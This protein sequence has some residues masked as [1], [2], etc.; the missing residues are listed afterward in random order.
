MPFCIEVDGVGTLPVELNGHPH[1]AAVQAAFEAAATGRVHRAEPLPP[2]GS[3]GP[4]YAL[5]QLS[6]DGQAA[7]GRLTPGGERLARGSLCLV[8]G[9]SSRALH[10]RED[11]STN[12]RRN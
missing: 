6:L 7:L 10:R 3:L 8:G 11:A 9:A 1:A 12:P 2:P 5:V 4:P